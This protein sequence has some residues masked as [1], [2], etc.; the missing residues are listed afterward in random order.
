[1]P[2]KVNYLYHYFLLGLRECD[3]YISRGYDYSKFF[4]LEEVS[5]IYGR[6]YVNFKVFTLAK[7]DVHILLSSNDIDTDSSYEI[8]KAIFFLKLKRSK[9]I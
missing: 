7:Q 3:V 8:S 5:R 2:S 4:K 6:Q 9:I 1:M